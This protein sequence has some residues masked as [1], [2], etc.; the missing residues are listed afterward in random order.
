MANCTTGY[1]K[2]RKICP[3]VRTKAKKSKD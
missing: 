1:S 3:R 2:L